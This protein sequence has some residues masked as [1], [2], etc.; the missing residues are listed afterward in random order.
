MLLPT[1][2]QL[3]ILCIS[4]PLFFNQNLNQ[5]VVT[6]KTLTAGEVISRIKENVTCDWRTETV[7]TYKAGTPETEVTGIATTF[8]ATLDVLKKAKAQ[9][10]NMVITH[11]PTFYNH[12]DDKAP[13]EDDPVQKAKIKFIE[14]NNMVVFRFHDHWHATQPDGIYKGMIEA[15]GWE[16]YH[17]E[18]QRIFNIPETTAKKLGKEISKTFGT[19]IVRVVGNPDM[20]I[21]NVG[22]VLGAAGSARHFAMLNEPN[23]DAIIIGEGR[24]W[25]TVEYV[26]DANTAGMPK[27]LF[28]MGHAD[29]EESGMIYCAEWLKGFINEIPVQFIEAGNPLWSPN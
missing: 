16:K 28:I 19:D 1:K 18:D 10:C 4:L 15:F 27:A 17:V 25:E 20:K 5:K 12:F 24:E 22:M 26:R 23:V 2:L 13:L 21:K 8:L 9:G 7:D 3:A 11:E 6:K 29:S 14:D